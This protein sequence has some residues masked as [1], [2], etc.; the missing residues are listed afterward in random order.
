VRTTIT[1]STAVSTNVVVS[2]RWIAST[3][4]NLE[5]MSP[6]FL[7]SNHASGSRSMWLKRLVRSFRLMLV[8][9]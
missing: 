3:L 9:R 8:L 6:M 1:P 2:V 5:T 4:R 7:F